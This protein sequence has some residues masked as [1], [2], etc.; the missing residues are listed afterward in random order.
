MTD[1]DCNQNRLVDFLYDLGGSFREIFEPGSFIRI[2]HDY[3]KKE[4][5]GP[6]EASLFCA[7]LYILEGAKLVSYA[8]AAQW[9]YES[10]QQSL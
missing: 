5:L 7:P 2:A 1:G 4:R 3:A 10:V 9:L 8:V 6:L